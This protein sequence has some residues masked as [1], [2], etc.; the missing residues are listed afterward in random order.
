MPALWQPAM[1]AF[2]RLC[3]V[4]TVYNQLIQGVHQPRLRGHHVRQQSTTCLPRVIV[5]TKTDV[6]EFLM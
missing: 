1:W 4:D 3:Y 6:F 5:T 2:Q